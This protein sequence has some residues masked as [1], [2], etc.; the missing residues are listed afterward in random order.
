MLAWRAFFIFRWRLSALN[1]QGAPLM[2]C[3]TRAYNSENPE[4]ERI[5]KN[6]EIG[7]GLPGIRTTAE[8][9]AAVK[10]AGLEVRI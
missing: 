8:V 4:H 9:D 1:I 3:L 6:V 2:Q 5:R 7:N 10:A